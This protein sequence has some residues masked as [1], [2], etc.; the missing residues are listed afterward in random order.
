MSLLGTSRIFRHIHLGSVENEIFF[1]KPFVKFR[2]FCV[3]SKN[4]A[5]PARMACESRCMDVSA[6]IPSHFGI[7]P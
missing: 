6:L 5:V 7:Y 4:Y 2:N 3:Y 1:Q